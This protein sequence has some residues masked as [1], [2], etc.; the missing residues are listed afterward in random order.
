[1]LAVSGATTQHCFTAAAP[2]VP[3]S[4]RSPLPRSRRR[5]HTD[6]HPDVNESIL[7]TAFQ[8]YGPIASMRICRDSITRKSLGYAYVNYNTLQDGAFA[9]RGSP[10]ISRDAARAQKNR[11]AAPTVLNKHLPIH[12]STRTLLCV[13]RRKP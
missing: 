11:R 5:T 4:R 3:R 13:Q 10:V 1:M 6:L 8:Q 7:F 9:A 2:A 12:N